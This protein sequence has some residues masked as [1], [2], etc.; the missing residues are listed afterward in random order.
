VF[1]SNVFALLGLRS[2]Y[3]ALAD[4]VV[5]FRHLKAGLAVVLVYAGLKM[6]VAPWVKIPALVSFSVI[7]LV[8]AAA[9]GWSLVETRSHARRRP[10]PPLPV[11]RERPA[12]R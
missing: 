1:T 6:M 5:R 12:A 8:L 11:R 9:V 4:W 7:L 3:F 2:L 10:A